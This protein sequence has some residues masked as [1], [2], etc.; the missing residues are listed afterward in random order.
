MKRV[1]K[2]EMITGMLTVQR[3]LSMCLVESS[4]TLLANEDVDWELIVLLI[5]NNL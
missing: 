4:L 3:V 2:L 5:L 1:K